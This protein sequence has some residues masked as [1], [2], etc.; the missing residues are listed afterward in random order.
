MM[1]LK[2][3]YIYYLLLFITAVLAM[4]PVVLLRHPLKYDIIDQA[5]PWRYFIGECLQNGHLP[6]WNPYQLLG[7]P[8]HADPQS[9]AWYPVTWF[10]GYFFGY[11]IYIISFDFFLHIFLAG[12]GMFYLAKQ[13]KFRNETAFIMGVSYMLSGFFIGNAQHFMWIISGTWI[14]FIIGAFLS[15]KN[16]PSVSAV[17]KTRAGLL[18]DHD[19][20]VPGIYFPFALPADSHLHPF[21][22]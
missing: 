4:L 1:D 9:S 7:S 8:I 5:Y 16:A 21:R 11:D 18:H 20:R 15:L 10:F 17:S 6:L 14:P 2:K 12:M 13:L 22:H 19:R 3:P